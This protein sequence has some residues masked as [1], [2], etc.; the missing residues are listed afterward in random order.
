[1]L[2]LGFEYALDLQFGHLMTDEDGIYLITILTEHPFLQPRIGISYRSDNT[3]D[4]TMPCLNQ[5][6]RGLGSRLIV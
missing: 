3:R 5:T 2:L 6:L 4:I 1:M